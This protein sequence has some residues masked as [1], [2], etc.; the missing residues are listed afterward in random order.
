MNTAPQAVT[1]L[2]FDHTYDTQNQLQLP[3]FDWID[4]TDLTGTMKYCEWQSFYAI[5]ERLHK[6]EKKG[7]TFLGSGDYHYVTFLLL[8]EL[9]R[10]FT[11][12]LYDNHTDVIQ[13]S[14]FSSLITCGS[15]VLWALEQLPML[16]KAVIIGA[17]LQL[18][19]QIPPHLKEK[20]AVFPNDS[21]VFSDTEAYRRQILREIPTNSVYISVDKDVLNKKYAATNWD[22]GKMELPDLLE[23]IRSIAAHK[24]IAGVDICGEYPSSP[25]DVLQTKNQQMMARNSEANEALLEVLQ[26]LPTPVGYTRQQKSSTIVSK[27][28]ANSLPH[29]P[30]T[31]ST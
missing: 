26:S 11:L 9:R 7:I 21:L 19:Q 30:K 29:R 20:I 22:H 24:S 18:I 14:F 15:W 6:R 5:Q 17:Q 27:E 10:P 23:S 25:L 1:V 2:N 28:S 16:Q 13:S 4:F 3:E 31:P 12:I 8:S